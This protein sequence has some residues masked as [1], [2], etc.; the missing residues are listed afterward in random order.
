MPA[1]VDRVTGPRA[2]AATSGARD[3]RRLF[4]W[5]FCVLGLLLALGGFLEVF[6]GGYNTATNVTAGTLG[7]GLGIL[8]YA[9]G[10]SRLGTATIIVSVIALFF[11]VAAT[12]G[13]IPGF[14]ETD[15]D[16]PAKEP[17]SE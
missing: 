8:G 17:A 13:L 12:Q 5:V 6:I 3:R 7:A 4:A 16:L 14:E 1:G 2:R 11:G 9:L 10:K 15:R